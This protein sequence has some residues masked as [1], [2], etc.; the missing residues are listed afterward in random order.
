M[1]SIRISAPKTARPG[2]VIE[3]KALIRHPMESGFRR[4]SRGEIIPR[5]IIV[6]FECLYNGEPVFTADFFPAVSANPFLSFHTRATESGTL[7]FRWTDQHGEVFA[8]SVEL[9]VEP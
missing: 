1:A 7:T 8:D 9:T 6:K 4:G 2:E 5:D 3:L